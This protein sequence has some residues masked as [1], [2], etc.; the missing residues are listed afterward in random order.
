MCV[1]REK[2]RVSRSAIS[3]A[4]IANDFTL[5]TEGEVFSFSHCHNKVTVAEASGLTGE[6]DEVQEFIRE[7]VKPWEPKLYDHLR[8]MS[9]YLFVHEFI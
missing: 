9:F 8:K 4:D 6:T 5:G 3:T 7:H 2:L 1:C